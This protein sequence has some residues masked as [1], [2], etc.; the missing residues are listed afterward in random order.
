ML[1][2]GDRD[3][4][5]DQHGIAQELVDDAAV[6]FDRLDH[7]GKVFVQ[8]VD[9]APRRHALDDA[10]EALDVGIENGGQGLRRPQRASAGD[11]R[12][13]NPSRHVAAE[14]LAQPAVGVFQLARALLHLGLERVGMAA[15]LLVQPGVLERDHGLRRE[16][17]QRS[18]CGPR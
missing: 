3:V 1:R 5:R 12:L 16:H 18:G 2:I 7:R 9:H 13:G 10:G 11:D 14:D 4:E 15:D 6:A 8:H 17:F